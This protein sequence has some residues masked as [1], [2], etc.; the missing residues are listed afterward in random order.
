MTTYSAKS[1][2]TPPPP[3]PS[4]SPLYALIIYR[5]IYSYLLWLTEGINRATDSAE[6]F[7]EGRRY[8]KVRAGAFIFKVA[9]SNLRECKVEKAHFHI[10]QILFFSR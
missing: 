8:M 3:P 10:S 2:L 9:G 1:G 6:S 4:L 7:N 5:P